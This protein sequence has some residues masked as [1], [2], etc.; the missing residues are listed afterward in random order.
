MRKFSFLFWAIPSFGVLFA[1]FGWFEWRCE[2]SDLDRLRLLVSGY[3]ISIASHISESAQA[4]LA[5]SY[6][7]STGFDFLL[8]SA[9]VALVCIGYSVLKS[10]LCKSQL[11]VSLLVASAFTGFSYFHHFHHES[12]F[13][14]WVFKRWSPLVDGIYPSSHPSVYL[15]VVLANIGVGMAIV[16]SASLHF[17][18]DR[19]RGV[20]GERRLIGI[21]NDIQAARTL[22]LA[23]T[24]AFTVGIMAIYFGLRVGV[25]H[26]P[27]DANK[28]LMGLVSSLATTYGIGYSVL[29]LTAFYPAVTRLQIEAYALVLEIGPDKS[30]EE[31]FRSFGIDINPYSRVRDLISV[32]APFLAAPAASLI[33]LARGVG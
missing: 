28:A 33:E 30:P 6:Q 25:A 23:A 5:S 32:L 27:P 4:D 18:Q 10:R 19:G 11:V 16:A 13:S 22:L 3:E 8:G 17:H 2:P 24:M 31:R 14:S 29:L 1:A 21:G 26:L 9:S 15:L 12:C 7:V 20:S